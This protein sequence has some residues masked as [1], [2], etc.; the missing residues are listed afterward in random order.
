MELLALCIALMLNDVRDTERAGS[1]EAVSAALGLDMADWWQPTA[2]AYFSR[3]T[4]ETILAAIEEGAG[5]EAARRI[6]G[7]SKGELARVAERELHGTRWLPRP[8]KAMAV[9]RVA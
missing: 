7:V 1:L 2:E 6:K 3:V 8:L 4:K 9:D 5:A